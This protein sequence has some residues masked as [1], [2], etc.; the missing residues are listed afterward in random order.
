M[1]AWRWPKWLH[2]RDAIKLNTPF[3]MV[4]SLISVQWGQSGVQVQLLSSACGCS[5]EPS[6]APHPQFEEAL[7]LQE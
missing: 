7:P 2:R 5:A 6:G 3:K 4:S 1:R